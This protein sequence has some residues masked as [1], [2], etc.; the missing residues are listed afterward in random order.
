M[1]LKNKLLSA[2]LA[3]C[4]VLPMTMPVCAEE[5]SGTNDPTTAKV[6]V[7]YTVEQSYKWSIHSEIDF[8]SNKGH[9]LIE[10]K[11]NV[12]QVTENVIPEGKK[13]SIKVKGDGADDAF[14]IRSGKGNG[15]VSI[16]YTVLS[17]V[18]SHVLNHSEVLS[19]AAGE[20]NKETKM[21][22]TLFNV[23][24]N[25]ETAEIAGAYLGHIIYTAEI[26]NA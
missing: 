12:I 15:N 14:T 21:T 16:T 18:T 22:F 4:M 26:V 25:G 5:V 9:Q 8:G 6:D 1:N 3:A 20:N 2:G 7:K 17:G 13:L 10:S 11:D 23:P 19:V 24:N